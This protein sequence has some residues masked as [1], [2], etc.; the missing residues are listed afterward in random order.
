[1]GTQ[2]AIAAQVV[3][4]QADYLL[5]LKG[6]QGQLHEAII[7]DIDECVANDFAGMNARRHVT[8]ETGHGREETR[9]Y[10]QMPAPKNLPG[11]GRW[12]GLWTVGVAVLTCV[13]DGKETGDIRSFLSSLDL[14]VKRFARA[15]RSHWSLDFTYREDESRIRDERL[16]ENVAWLNRFTLSPL[17]QHPGKDSLVMKRR[18]CGWND[19]FLM[20]VLTGSST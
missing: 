1:M 19:N 11:F 16:R 13:R 3:E 18:A 8:K 5:A 20:K 2:T 12:K 9:T 17:K 14:G 4:G 10:V 7:D 15:V 6:N